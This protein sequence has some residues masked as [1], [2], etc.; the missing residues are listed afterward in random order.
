MPIWIGIGISI[1]KFY[2]CTWYQ[3]DISDVTIS[4]AGLC[5]QLKGEMP[6]TCDIGEAKY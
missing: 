2:L 4:D 3:K 6:S 1:G 5:L